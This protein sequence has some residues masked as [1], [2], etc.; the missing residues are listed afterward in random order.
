MFAALMCWVLGGLSG[1]ALAET[2]AVIIYLFH[3]L[4]QETHTEGEG[5]A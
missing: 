5:A 3:L 1:R 4:C 2:L